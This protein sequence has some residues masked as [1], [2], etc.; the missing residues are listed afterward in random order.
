MI[1]NIYYHDNIIWGWES[2]EDSQSTHSLY[3]ANVELARVWLDNEGQWRVCSIIPEVEPGIDGENYDENKDF[4]GLPEAKKYAEQGIRTWLNRAAKVL[5]N[6][7]VP[8]RT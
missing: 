1:H 4:E 2:N 6:R 5:I 7:E 8:V 3:L